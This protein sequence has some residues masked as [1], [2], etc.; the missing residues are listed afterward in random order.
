M[1][2]AVSSYCWSSL[3]SPCPSSKPSPRCAFFCF[4]GFGMGVTIF[5]LPA[6]VDDLL[7]RLPLLVEF[8]MT[9]RVAVRRV[10]DRLFK[11]RI[12]QL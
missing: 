6:L 12:I 3:E 2:D 11:K 8:P 1:R 4:L 5:G 9:A 10:K 7:R